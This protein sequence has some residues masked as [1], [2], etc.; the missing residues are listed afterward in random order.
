[1]A[2]SPILSSDNVREICRLVLGTG[3]TVSRQS[4][5]VGLPPKFVDMLPVEKNPV[6]QILSDLNKMN[7]VR[8]LSDGTIPLK[9]W[10][11]NAMHLFEVLPQGEELRRMYDGIQWL[12]AQALAQKG[13]QNAVGPVQVNRDQSAVPLRQNKVE[14]DRAPAKVQAPQNKVLLSSGPPNTQLPVTEETNGTP[15]EGEGIEEE[16]VGNSATPWWQVY[17]LWGGILAIL[18]IIFEA[19]TEQISVNARL[20][21]QR[22][23]WLVISSA[24]IACGV[25]AVVLWRMISTGT[26]EILYSLG[27]FMWGSLVAW[28]LLVPGY[29]AIETFRAGETM[30]FR[31]AL[32]QASP[33]VFYLYPCWVLGFL[34][35]AG[36]LYWVRSAREEDEPSQEG[37]SE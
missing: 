12:S 27:A 3:L 18:I 9:V 17:L 36:V 32:D 11:E 13:I 34:I 14:G 1:M 35:G 5:L 29:A 10:M 24:V 7:Q 31:G 8:I 19:T 26:R 2:E 4:L 37:I 23:S 21:I 25:G 28:L 33:K 15:N 22:H 6:E 30:Y 16:P 20:A